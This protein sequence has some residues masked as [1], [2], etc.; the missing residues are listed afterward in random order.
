MVFVID[1][2]NDIFMYMK[3]VHCLQ[4]DESDEARSTRCVHQ[5]GFVL[6]RLLSQ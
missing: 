6:P 5:T 1:I 2:F 4:I 3:F